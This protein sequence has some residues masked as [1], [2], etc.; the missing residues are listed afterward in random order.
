MGGYY[1]N[2]LTRKHG[3]KPGGLIFLAI[4]NCTLSPEVWSNLIASDKGLCS[5]LSPF[6]AN[7]LSPTCKAPVFSAK[8]PETKIINTGR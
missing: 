6:I 7:I 1:K 5:K 3:Y 2:Y 8:P 4:F